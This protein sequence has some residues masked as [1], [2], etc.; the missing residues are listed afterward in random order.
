MTTPGRTFEGGCSE[1][2][3]LISGLLDGELDAGTEAT[4]RGHL[5]ACPSCR[6]ERQI[7]AELSSAL[8]ADQETSQPQPSSWASIEAAVKRAG[9]PA[10]VPRPGFPSRR[11][12]A[13]LA[14]AAVLVLVAAGSVLGFRSLVI[15]NRSSSSTLSPELIVGLVDPTRSPDFGSFGRR[16]RIERASLEELRRNVSFEPIAPSELPGGYVFDS[17]WVITLGACRMVC[18]RYSHEGRLLAIVQSPSD[19]KAMC[20]LHK[21]RCCIMAGQACRRL[22]IDRVDILQTT[23]GPLDLTVAVPVGATNIDT[24]MA[25]LVHSQATVRD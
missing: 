25:S 13:V 21:P 17:G 5:A 23:R 6:A 19:C 24:L 3:T 2:R 8:R 9:S 18:L 20:N 7:L 10:P 12:V 15:A 11:L 1:M 16:P 22:S 14:S 4:V